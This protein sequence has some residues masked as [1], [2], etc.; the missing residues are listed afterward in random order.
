MTFS[1]RRCSAAKRIASS[2]HSFGNERHAARELAVRTL[3]RLAHEQEA[4]PARP[5]ARERHA[6]DAEQVVARSTSVNASSSRAWN[7]SS[8][9]GTLHGSA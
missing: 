4:R 3:V 6:V 1:R 9:S 7:S 8:V 5:A 2:H